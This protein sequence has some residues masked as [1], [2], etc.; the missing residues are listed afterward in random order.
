MVNSVLDVDALRVRRGGHEI[1]KGIDFRMPAGRITGLLGPS[2]CGKTTLMRA[3]IGTQALSGGTIT[4]LGRSAGDPRLRTEIGYASQAAS[5][6]DD[7]TVVENLRYFATAVRARGDV[8]K[9]MDQVD[10]IAHA[11][12]LTGS[13]SS[14]QRSRVNLAVAML[15][16]PRLLVLD[17][18][19]VGLDPVLRENLWSLFRDLSRDGTSLLVSSHVMDEADRCDELLLMRDGRLLTQD[20]PAALKERTGTDSLDRA[21][22]HLVADEPVPA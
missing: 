14:G 2:G 20:T 9:V 17:E 19:T 21:F 11:R 4:V 15:G 7:L 6:Y 1:L 22:L 8:Q 5:V 16:T 3:I 13:L 18:P 10:L 12:R